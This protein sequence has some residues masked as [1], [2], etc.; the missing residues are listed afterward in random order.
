MSI[1]F[2]YQ[3]S[4][5]VDPRVIEAMIP[6][7]G[8]EY[9]N[10]SSLHLP[11]DEASRI[12]EECRETIAG[13]I[14]AKPD[15]IVFTSGATESNN[16][17]L[18]G[19]SLRNRAKGNH[20]IISEI[21]HISIHNIAKYLTKNGFEVSKV[22]VDQYGRIDIQK[23]LGRITEKTILVSVG[24]ASNE[25]G[26][27][28]SALEIGELCRKKKIAFHSDAVAAQ[29]LLP[30]DVG[31]DRI[32]LLTLSSNDIYGPK[33]VGVLYVRKGIRVN[34]MI[35][36]GGQEK[37]L[38]SGSENI[39]GIVG[40]KRAVE[41]MEKEME[42]EVERL[43]KYRDRLIRTIPKI[44]PRCHLN[45]H[46]KQRLANNAHFRFE[47]IEGESLLLSLKDKGISVS[48]G[49]ACSSMTLE[50]SHT[51]ISL[52][53]LHE[54][55]HGSLEFTLGRFNKEE[56]VDRLLQVLPEVV[57]RLREMSPLY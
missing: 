47:G 32:D 27:I 51:L 48:T 35:I 44:I 12:L 17:A 23:L 4:K 24:Y 50:P 46:P 8:D 15:E 9:G 28:Q 57:E 40:M 25:I 18:I 3:S 31:R 19:F 55:A 26:T 7:Y 37:G 53:L 43:G 16:L 14:K 36:G 10:P 1:Y 13:F 38:R 45:G 42:G 52:G 54:E 5:P 6:Y 11:G 49:S 20:I 39:P 41:I 56:D 22:P 2:D 33:G 29:G 30:L 34:P 21:E